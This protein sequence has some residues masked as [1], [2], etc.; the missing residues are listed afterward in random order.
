MPKGAA[1]FWKQLL[2]LSFSLICALSIQRA[3]STEG[4]RINAGPLIHVR[5]F[6]RS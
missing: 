5:W 3:A 6:E 4:R 2:R 1:E